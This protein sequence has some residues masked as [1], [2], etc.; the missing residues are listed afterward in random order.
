MLAVVAVLATA[1]A[2][3]A[4]QQSLRWTSGHIAREWTWWLPA[5][6][7][8]PMALA[9][10]LPG[11]SGSGLACLWLVP[12]TGEVALGYRRFGGRGRAR[13]NRPVSSVGTVLTPLEQPSVTHELSELEPAADPQVTQHLTR[14]H[15]IEGDDLI[16][17]WLRARLDPGQRT[18]HAH[19]SFCPPFASV[20]EMEFEQT[21]GPT[22]HVKLGQVLAYGVR[23]EVKLDEI[24]PAEV[25]IAFSARGPQLQK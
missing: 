10:T 24:G 12:I 21:N 11:T 23:F 5:A 25:L 1:A 18:A 22:A 9:L 15:T 13:G 19:V 2:I 17:G 3:I 8:V 4:Q 14:R 20:P 16:E 6:A 7:L